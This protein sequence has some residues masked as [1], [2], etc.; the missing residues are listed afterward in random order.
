MFLTIA[1]WF[2][3]ERIFKLSRIAFMRREQK[4]DDMEQKIAERTRYYKSVYNADIIAVTG[5]T[6]EISST[7]IRRMLSSGIPP[8]RFIKPKVYDYIRKNKLYN[9]DEFKF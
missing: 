7:E 9:G 5:E 6:F 4:S 3:P 8:D 2:R 1:E